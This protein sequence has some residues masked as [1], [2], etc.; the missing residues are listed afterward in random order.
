MNSYRTTFFLFGLSI[1]VSVFSSC[2]KFGGAQGPEKVL[3]NLSHIYYDPGLRFSLDSLSV[4]N[5]RISAFHQGILVLPGQH[6]VELTYSDANKECSQQT[7][8]ISNK[9]YSKWSCQSKFST[10]ANTSYSLTPT[11]DGVWIQADDKGII[12]TETDCKTTTV[13]DR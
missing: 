9:C 2:S 3:G 7:T 8:D 10:E 13:A 12:V 6:K 4:D 11:V 1:L 5:H